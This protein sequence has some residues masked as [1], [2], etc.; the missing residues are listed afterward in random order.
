MKLHEITTGTRP[1]RDLTLSAYENLSSASR[2][3][4]V[5]MWI[6]R[7]AP[8]AIW[9]NEDEG[10]DFKIYVY[11]YADDPRAI[12]DIAAFGDTNGTVGTRWYLDSGHTV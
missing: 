7:N 1:I 10:C 11:E 12:A 8:Y 4:I 9:R 2:G 3:R 5:R 6:E